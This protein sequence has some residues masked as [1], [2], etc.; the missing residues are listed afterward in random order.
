MFE[1][2]ESFYRIKKTINDKQIDTEIIVITFIG[3]LLPENVWLF[4]NKFRVTPYISRVIQCTKC[5]LYGKKQAQC[6]GRLRCN[7]CGQS[8]D[9]CPN[10]LN[11]LC[12]HCGG[13]QKNI[14][15]SMS[16]RKV[17]TMSESPKPKNLL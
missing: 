9:D 3:Q 10:K 17:K 4:N 15:R 2:I 16:Y 13:S 6:K 5:L 7:Y 11:P 14:I 8:H 12:F 1:S